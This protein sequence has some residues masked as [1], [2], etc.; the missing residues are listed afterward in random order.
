MI[1]SPKQLSLGSFIPYR[2][3]SQLFSLEPL[4]SSFASGQEN[5]LCGEFSVASVSLRLRG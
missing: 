3:V 4:V 2:R 5:T 1:R